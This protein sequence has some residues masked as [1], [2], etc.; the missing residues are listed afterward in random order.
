MPPHK[1]EISPEQVRK[2]AAIGCTDVEIGEIVGCSHDTLTRRFR[3]ELD[4]GRANGKASLR[5][6]Q[7]ELAL[8]GNVTMLIWLGKQ[9]LGQVDKQV[10]E[11]SHE[12]FEVIIGQ[13]VQNRDR[14]AIAGTVRV[15]DEPGEA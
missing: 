6:K 9:M 1:L 2:L 15:L 8:S 14:G 7:M 4:D 11:N 13:P 5:R 3:Q 12:V 10:V